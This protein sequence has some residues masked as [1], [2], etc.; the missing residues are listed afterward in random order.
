[1][2]PSNPEPSQSV[3]A[4][5]IAANRLAERIRANDG[6]HPIDS[7]VADIWEAENLSAGG[8]LGSE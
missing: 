3:L 2:N 5:Y 4:A 7:D 8:L 6:G 1:M